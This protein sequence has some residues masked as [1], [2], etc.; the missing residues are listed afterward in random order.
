LSTPHRTARRSFTPDKDGTYCVAA[1][2]GEYDE[3]NGSYYGTSTLAVE[4]V[5]D[6]M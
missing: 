2:G 4:E 5:V 1:A 3:H 6:A